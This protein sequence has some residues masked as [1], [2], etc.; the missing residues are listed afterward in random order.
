M[1]PTRLGRGEISVH[2]HKNIHMR[3]RVGESEFPIQPPME[4]GNIVVKGVKKIY[5]G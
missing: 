1:S 2:V 5:S 3:L 4:V